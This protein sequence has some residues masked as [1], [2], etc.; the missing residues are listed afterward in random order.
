[1]TKH[2]A[3][4]LVNFLLAKSVLEALLVGALA[5]IFFIQ[6][7]PPVFRGW[8]EATV[9]SIAGWVVNVDEPWQRVEVQLFIDNVFIASSKADQSRPDLVAAGWASDEWHG[10]EF[11]VPPL[12]S[13]EHEARVYALHSSRSKT[14]GTLQ[15]VGD[16]IRFRQNPDGRLSVV[17]GQ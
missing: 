6:A 4:T 2:S 10:Y 7:F 3:R 16:P 5:V 13:G 17:S 11:R 14:L 9:T 12:S 8:G 15:L 1:M